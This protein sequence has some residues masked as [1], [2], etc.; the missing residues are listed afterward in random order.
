MRYHNITKDDMKNG[1]GLRTV[2]WVAGCGHRCPGCHNPI[3]WDAQGGLPFDRAA[4]EELMEAAGGAKIT[5]K[6][7]TA[8]I[9]CKPTN[10]NK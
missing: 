7:Y 3:T 2:L 6:P 5:A 9:H 4:G 1:S 10:R 8:A